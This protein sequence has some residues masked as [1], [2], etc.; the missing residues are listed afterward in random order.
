[1]EK[2]NYPSI[3]KPQMT[4]YRKKPI[5]EIPD[6]QNLYDFIFESNKDNMKLPAIE[7]MGHSLSFTELREKIDAFSAGLLDIGVRQG[8]VVLI[9]LMNSP[10]VAVSLLAIN[11]I[12]AVSKWF[13][14]RAGEKDIETYARDSH[15]RYLII[16][17]SLLPKVKGIIN[18]TNVEKIVVADYSFP[19]GENRSGNDVNK[20]AVIAEYSE[21]NLVSYRDLIRNGKGVSIPRIQQK[22][23]VPAVMVMSSGTTG[24]PKTIVH[25]SESIIEAIRKQNYADLPL[26]IGK[27]V[28]AILPPCLAYDLVSSILSPLSLGCTVVLSPS[29]APD[30]MI[31]Y[32]GD[33]TITPA[34]PFHYRYI[35]AHYSELTEK[36]KHQIKEVDC[37]V[38]GGDKLPEKENMELE[39][40]FGA[41]V[42]GGYGNNEACAL[43]C[44]NPMNHN[45]YGTVGIPYYG[46]TVIAYDNNTEEE[47]KYGEV[48]EICVLC[49]SL[50]L[51]YE[52]DEEETNRVKRCHKDGKVWMHTGDLGFVDEEGFVTLLGRIGRVI[53]RR[54]FKIAATTIENC[55]LGHPD[56]KECVAVEVPD[57]EEEQVPM[58]FVVINDEE[59]NKTEDEIRTS[60]IKKC[61]LELKEYEIPKYIQ[62]ISEMPYTQ[63]GKQDF[64]R[65]EEIGEKLVK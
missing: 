18:E 24:M 65:L 3:D 25:S 46:E 52:G 38:S 8:D 41:P 49:K 58:A 30:A 26:E 36:Q 42:V 39:K 19:A 45:K 62:F 37:F 10:E 11:L 33:F 15:C 28:L 60:I 55:I 53:V 56:V 13:D 23:D 40:L 47:L 31:P 2:T 59:A 61:S 22:K 5:R 48:G 32:I 34:V 63:N 64:R 17:E 20:T 14:V 27:R 21:L 44:L 6:V 7:Y 35:A 16:L 50:F 29:F 1:M 54:A 4:Y 9:G 51:Y 12:G 43:I 57:K